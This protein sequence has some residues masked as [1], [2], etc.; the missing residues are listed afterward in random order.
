MIG[1]NSAIVWLS[2]TGARFARLVVGAYD[3]AGGPKPT[4]V[5]LVPPD[6]AGQSAV[7]TLLLAIR[8]IAMAD[9]RIL[10][11]PEVRASLRD[12]QHPQEPYQHWGA[13]VS[14]LESMNCRAAE[15]ILSERPSYLIS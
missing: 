3:G 9:A 15:V 6:A 13:R 1:S 8:G 10:A 7:F 5:I 11:D 2:T 4:E 12:A 14:L